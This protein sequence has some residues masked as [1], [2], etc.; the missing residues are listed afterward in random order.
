MEL[1]VAALRKLRERIGWA[2]LGS[3]FSAVVMGR[4][5][6]LC[7]LYENEKG[8]DNSVTMHFWL[9][10]RKI[11]PL[12]QRVVEE[13]PSSQESENAIKLSAMIKLDEE[14]EQSEVVGDTSSA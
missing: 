6:W 12:V 10:V 1:W 5:G 3:A 9:L 13:S 11:E 8:A 7:G 4:I 2:M 14:Y